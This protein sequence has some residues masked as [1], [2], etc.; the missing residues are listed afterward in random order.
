[1]KAYKLTVEEY[2]LIEHIMIVKDDFV[3]VIWSTHVNSESFYDFVTIDQFKVENNS[4]IWK[5]LIRPDAARDWNEKDS[6]AISKLYRNRNSFEII[7]LEQLLT[8][9]NPVV[10]DFI[11]K[12]VD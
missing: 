10:R 9:H 5:K 7:E 2:P 1:M 6:K 3:Y 11:K 12:F 8:H 4:L